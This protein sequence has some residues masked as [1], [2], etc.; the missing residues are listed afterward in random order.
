MSQ[1]LQ[2]EYQVMPNGT[3]RARDVPLAEKMKA[4]EAWQAA[5]AR[6]VKEELGSVLSPQP[7]VTCT[8]CVSLFQHGLCPLLYTACWLTIGHERL[9]PCCVT[10]LFPAR[11]ASAV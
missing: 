11:F 2:E 7:R 3:K 5:V 10:L 6:A 1:V 4:G 8:T 9:H